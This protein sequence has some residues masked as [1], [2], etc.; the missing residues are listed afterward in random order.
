MARTKFMACTGNGLWMHSVSEW[1][2]WR[3]KIWALL[4]G[5]RLK[6]V[7]SGYLLILLIRSFCFA[8][9]LLVLMHGW[10]GF[11]MTVTFCPLYFHRQSWH[12]QHSLQLC[13]QKT[14]R[15]E[16]MES[17]QMMYA[18]GFLSCFWQ[19]YWSTGQNYSKKNRKK[20][21]PNGTKGRIW[22]GRWKLFQVPHVSPFS[23][24]TWLPG[25][26][27]IAVEPLATAVGFVHRGITQSVEP[28]WWE[29]WW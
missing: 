20:N 4:P 11:G 28:T 19:T 14:A 9:L 25:A 6:F 13:N 22:W 7:C 26:M 17:K 2:A 1:P 27:E 15:R 23:H 18:E 16:V 8:V 29:S 21:S 5:Y 24:H 12:H 3:N 10:E